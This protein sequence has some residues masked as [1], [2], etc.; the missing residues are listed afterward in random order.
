MGENEFVLKS[1]LN[2]VSAVF[3]SF[4]WVVARNSF[5]FTDDG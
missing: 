4:V 1:G 5:V 2:S 3:E